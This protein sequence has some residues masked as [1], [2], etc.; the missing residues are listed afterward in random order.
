MT[1]YAILLVFVLVAA[2]VG[3][4]L[5][6]WQNDPANL[7]HFLRS[8]PG[9]LLVGSSVWLQAIGIVWMSRLARIEV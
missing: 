8:E 2:T 1:T 4:A 9:S 6:M 7:A 3:V 5:L